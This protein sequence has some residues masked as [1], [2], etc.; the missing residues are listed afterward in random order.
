MKTDWTYSASNARAV[1][2]L[3]R[4]QFVEKML[5]E[6]PFDMHVCR[7]EGRDAYEFPR[8]LAA[9]LERWSR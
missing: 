1:Q 7:L 5:A 3:A 6:L 9:E 2:E 4:H 8:M